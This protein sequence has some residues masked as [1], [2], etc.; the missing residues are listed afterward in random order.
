[1]V[2]PRIYPDLEIALQGILASGPAVNAIGK[3]SRAVV[4]QGVAGAIHP[5]LQPDG[6][7]KIHNA[8][9]FTTAV[10]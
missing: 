6:S 4:A 3:S 5:Y 9:V 7:Y 8:F 10:K 2:Y 1:V